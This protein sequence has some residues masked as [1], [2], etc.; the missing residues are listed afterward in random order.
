MKYNPSLGQEESQLSMP[1]DWSLMI[2]DDFQGK[3]YRRPSSQQ[4]VI[5]ANQPSYI[6]K[7]NIR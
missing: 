6:E 3:N 1:L 5:L 4:V 2:F 7:Q